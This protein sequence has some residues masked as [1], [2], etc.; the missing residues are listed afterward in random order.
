MLLP[1]TL[2]SSERGRFVMMNPAVS[3]D[4]ASVVE[5]SANRKLTSVRDRPAF[6]KFVPAS[7]LSSR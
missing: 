7:H 1:P 5:K 4:S 3:A 2:L 6:S